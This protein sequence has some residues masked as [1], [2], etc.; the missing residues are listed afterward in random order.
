M[1]NVYSGFG[2]QGRDQQQGR[3]M[4]ATKY[5]QFVVMSGFGNRNESILGASRLVEM[6]TELG[7]C[8]ERPE[9]PLNGGKVYGETRKSNPYRPYRNQ[10]NC[11]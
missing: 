7:R 9:L 2:T 5:V 8:R 1:G 11:C 6:I 3:A 10:S 4:R